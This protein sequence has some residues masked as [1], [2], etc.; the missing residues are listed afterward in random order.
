VFKFTDQLRAYQ[1][2]STLVK[3]VWQL[4]LNKVA[5]LAIDIHKVTLKRDVKWSD[6]CK[7]NKTFIGNTIQQK[8]RRNM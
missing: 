6:R 4:Y 2:T 8:L 5:W 1:T 7:K 3:W